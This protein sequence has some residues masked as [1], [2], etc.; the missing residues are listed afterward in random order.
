MTRQWVL[1]L[2]LLLAVLALVGIAFFR[3]GLEKKSAPRPLTELNTQQV[4]NI[5]I[6][7][8]T[9][10][11]VVLTRTAQQW[12]MEK[13][14]HARA[15]DFIVNNVLEI[16]KAASLNQL[17]YNA[18]TDAA[19]Y[20]FAKPGFILHLDN[21]RIVFG[22]TNP[23]TQQ[24]YVLYRGQVHLISPSTIWAVS[25]KP[26]E[27]LD[28]RLLEFKE[29]PTAIYFSDG[30]KLEL[31]NGSWALQPKMKSMATD[32]LTRLVNEWRYVGATEVQPY[33]HAPLHG[34]IRVVYNGKRTIELGI[35][36]RSPELILL[37]KDENLQY[38][39][40]ASTASRLLLS[41]LNR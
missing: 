25:H 7:R 3:P 2:S 28:K 29:T 30:K 10:D 18:D 33:K 17:P 15:S 5:T 35:I 26:A 23:L 1:N 11:P 36:S 21:E 8:P 19:K 31:K 6:D 14:F 40:P 32:S 16:A 41:G 12:M 37:R 4:K 38:Y 20:G 39:F 13:P 9:H 34:T 22:D 24:R 27:F